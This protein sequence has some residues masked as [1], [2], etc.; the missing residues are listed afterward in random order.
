VLGVLSTRESEAGGLQ[1]Q[2]QPGQ[3][4]KTL[5]QKKKMCYV[6]S[7]FLSDLVSK[8]SFHWK[9]LGTYLKIMNLQQYFYLK[10][11]TPGFPLFSIWVSFVFK[12]FII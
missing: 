12:I 8:K 5:S 9:E 4:D 3:R 10:F 6:S 11:D 7:L 1:V 2:S